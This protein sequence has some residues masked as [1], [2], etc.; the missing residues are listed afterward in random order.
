MA[1]FYNKTLVSSGAE[2]TVHVVDNTIGE[3]VTINVTLIDPTVN[4][5]VEIYVTD[6]EVSTDSALLVKFPMGL[7]SG[8]IALER[9]DIWMLQFMRII[10]KSTEDVAI[11]TYGQDGVL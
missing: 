4:A 5:I 7:S 1:I 10:V 11:Q 6:E 3:N 8:V 9:T 2:T